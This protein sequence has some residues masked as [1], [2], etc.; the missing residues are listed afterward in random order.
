MELA[1]TSYGLTAA[2]LAKRHHLRVRTV[3][4]DLH[5]L[6]A[7]G[8]PLVSGDGARWKLVEGWEQRIPFPLPAGQLLALNVARSLMAPIRGTP[9][10]REFN[11]LCERLAGPSLDR[12]KVQGELFPRLR[13]VLV[14]R[15]QLAIDYSEYTALLEALCR[16]CES[17]TTVRAVYYT[18]SRSELTRREIDPYFL[19][20]DPQ[21][22]ALYV[23]AWCHWRR[24]VRTFA[25]HRF[26]R[27][28]LTERTFERPATFT[29]EGYL[30]GAFRVWRGNAAVTICLAIDPDIAGWVTERRWHASQKVRRRANGAC[31]ITFVVDGVLEVRRF[32]LQLGAAAEVIGPPWFRREIA[33]EQSRAAR[34]NHGTSE[35]RL[36]LDDTGV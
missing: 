19:Y 1:R 36:A 28:A 18:E 22:E 33:L 10:A 34:R 26:R 21:L 24:E 30:R 35:Q 9:V 20:Y 12:S 14:T 8:F 15:S 27:V 31:E 25:V 3:Y 23:F 32:I 17:R 6:E 5:A 16:G 7:I 4:R 13:A 11:A 29:V 2:S